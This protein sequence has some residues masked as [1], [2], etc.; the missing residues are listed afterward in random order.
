MCIDQDLKKRLTII[1][2]FWGDRI[3]QKFNERAD[4]PF[5]DAVLG[6]FKTQSALGSLRMVSS[7]KSLNVPSEM[8]RALKCRR[9]AIE[10]SKEYSL[11]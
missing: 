6:F 3:P 1:P 11:A 9:S 5:V 8:T 2:R 10:I 4:A 7:A